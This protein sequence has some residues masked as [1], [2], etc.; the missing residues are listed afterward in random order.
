MDDGPLPVEAAR[1]FK[2]RARTLAELADGAH[3]LYAPVD[4]DPALLAQHLTDA[5]RDP[6]RELAEQLAVGEWTRE[7]ISAHV[8]AAVTRHKLKMPQLMMPLRVI[9]TGSAQTP[10][11]DAVLA[12]SPRERVLERLRRHLG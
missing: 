7:A 6:L 12:L 10:S 5:V 4:P 1:L 8:K 9:A 11:I 3:L 2:D